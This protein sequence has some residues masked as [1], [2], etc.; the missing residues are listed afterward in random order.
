MLTRWVHN[1]ADMIY[2]LYVAHA[3]YDPDAPKTVA[4]LQAARAAAQAATSQEDPGEDDQDMADDAW[5][6]AEDDGEEEDSANDT[7]FVDSDQDD[8]DEEIELAPPTKT[9]R[10]KVDP[11]APARTVDELRERLAQR[12]RDIQAAKA[13]RAAAKKGGAQSQSRRSDGGN[14]DDDD[15]EAVTGDDEDLVGAGGDEAQSKEDL[16]EERRRR[17]LMRDNR[18]KKRK[19]ERRAKGLLAKPTRG[20]EP[21]NGRKGGGKANAVPR[22]PRDQHDGG[23]DGEDTSRPRK[24]TKVGGVR[25]LRSSCDADAMPLTLPFGQSAVCAFCCRR[26]RACFV[27]QKGRV[28]CIQFCASS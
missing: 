4:E 26:Q 1:D 21:S 17:G 15:E 2:F 14:N 9:S 3:Q 12:I 19:E 27:K 5:E 18:R 10:A 6:D 25:P 28:S 20:Q 11:N 7:D 23:D 13:A 8:D 16:L 24:K 22:E